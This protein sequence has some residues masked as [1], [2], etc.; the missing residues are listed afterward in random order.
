MSPS[1]TARAAAPR[2]A[3]PR[4]SAP[5]TRARTQGRV[6]PQSRPRTQASQPSRGLRTA[7]DESKRRHPSAGLSQQAPARKP[8]QRAAKPNL[9]LAPKSGLRFRKL[10]FISFLTGLI[11]LVGLPFAIVILHASLVGGQRQLDDIRQDLNQQLELRQELLYERSQAISPER[12]RSVAT[13]TLGMVEAQDII[14]LQPTGT[15]ADGN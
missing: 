14:Y 1:A 15:M 6:Q 3:V 8:V 5:G 7:L 12:I 2:A 9:K 10:Y 13:Q 4:A 11:A